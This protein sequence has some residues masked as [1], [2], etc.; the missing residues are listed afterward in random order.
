MNECWNGYQKFV[1]MAIKNVIAD[2]TKGE[3]FDGTNYMIYG[4][5]KFN[6][7][8]MNKSYQTIFPLPQIHLRKDISHNTTMTKRLIE[9][10]SREIIAHTLFG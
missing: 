10:G 8:W 4:I 3:K 9:L 1:A 2:L 5:E 7:S 6:I